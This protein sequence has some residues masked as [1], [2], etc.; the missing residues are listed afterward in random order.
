MNHINF[1]NEPLK[2]KILY[3]E[4]LEVLK[5]IFQTNDFSLGKF[6]NNVES[7]NSGSQM[8]P[9]KEMLN[10]LIIFKEDEEK[11]ITSK[12]SKVFEI[13][14]KKFLFLLLV[15]I[16]SLWKIYFLPRILSKMNFIE[17]KEN[18]NKNEDELMYNLNNLLKMTSNSVPGTLIPNIAYETV[19]GLIDAQDLMQDNKVLRFRL[20]LC[21]CKTTRDIIFK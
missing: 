1:I 19:K 10:S 17:W 15:Y 5:K 20:S 14:I 13:T 8:S 16:P 6:F 12:E 4:T 18:P 7:L 11:I 2:I 9:S 21:L 3:F